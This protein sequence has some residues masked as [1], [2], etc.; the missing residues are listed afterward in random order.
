M[1]KMNKSELIKVTYHW[2]NNFEHKY[3]KLVAS[4]NVIWQKVIENAPF[5]HQT[6][7]LRMFWI[8]KSHLFCILLYCIIIS[9]HHLD[10]EKEEIVI[11]NKESFD[12]YLYYTLGLSPHHIHVREWNVN[13][14]PKKTSGKSYNSVVHDNIECDGC[15]ECPIVGHMYKCMECPNYDLCQNCMLDKIH[16]NHNMLQI[17][18]SKNKKKELSSTSQNFINSNNSIKSNKSHNAS[19][20]EESSNSWEDASDDASDDDDKEDMNKAK[21]YNCL[22][23]M[24][25]KLLWTSTT[26]TAETSSTTDDESFYMD[27]DSSTWET[28]N[29]SDEEPEDIWYY[30]DF[31][32]TEESSDEE[33]D[34]DNPNCCITSKYHKTLQFTKDENE[35]SNSS[36]DSSDGE[37][38]STASD[39][40]NPNC[41]ATVKED[42]DNDDDLNNLVKSFVLI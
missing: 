19:E 15:F 42:T 17:S 30:S 6:N 13:R 10:D 21:P 32:T 24:Y 27:S 16:I 11:D 25:H 23:S 8:G 20:D 36:D 9:I 38:S 14:K 7:N 5:S 18:T 1:K 37:S 35:M 40:E 12:I 3:I 26:D 34:E 22:M 41:S 31:Y 4:F 29:S 39:K 2:G 28:I 33:T